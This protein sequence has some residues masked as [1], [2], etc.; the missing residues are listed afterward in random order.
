MKKKLPVLFC[1]LIINKLL[2]A[3][4]ITSANSFIAGDVQTV[5]VNN[6]ALS[7]GPNGNNVTWNFDTL[8][9][10]TDTLTTTYYT[11][12][13]TPF[14][15]SFPTANIASS[16][17]SG[18][19]SYYNSGT[20]ANLNLGSADM[21]NS[22]VFVN[23]IQYLSFPMV[24]N[25][26]YTDSA[27]AHLLLDFGVPATGILNANINSN[28]DATGTLVL[29]SG[30]FNNVLRRKYENIQA[31]DITFNGSTNTSFD[32]MTVYEWFEPSTKG[33]LLTIIKRSDPFA[34]GGFSYTNQL[35]D[36]NT[37][38]ISEK[39]DGGLFEISPNPLNDDNINININSNKSENLHIEL[40][41]AL[42]QKVYEKTDFVYSSS[43]QKLVINIP[44]L[45]KGVYF[46]RIGNRNQ[47][48]TKKV[49][50]D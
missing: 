30:T 18:F 39:L 12:S 5:F 38:G 24:Y 19:Y 29:P 7:P 40:I 20:S 48:Y 21:N 22:F 28:C 46:I 1:L 35:T 13:S 45:G 11:P 43:N 17:G 50:K 25:S 44:S 32:T 10:F 2:M 33:P 26:N 42:G 14:A 47:T 31:V 36:L 37:V 23:P 8:S 41:N 4:S 6:Y 34:I 16:D 15:S 49:I 9:Y 3:Q 27:I